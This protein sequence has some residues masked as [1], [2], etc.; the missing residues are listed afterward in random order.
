LLERFQ[1]AW[2]GEGALA[3]WPPLGRSTHR[4]PPSQRGLR[5]A[6]AHRA[7]RQDFTIE[8]IDFCGRCRR[9]AANHG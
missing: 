8:P 9:S 7:W 1:E 4:L 2:E 3:F 5:L 6:L